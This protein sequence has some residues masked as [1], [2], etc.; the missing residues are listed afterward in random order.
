MTTDKYVNV[1]W[2]D[3]EVDYDVSGSV[4]HTYDSTGSYYP[5]IA[6]CIDEITGFSSNATTI[7]DKI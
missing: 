7:W 2:G 3:G 4:S 6:G 5:V 1:F